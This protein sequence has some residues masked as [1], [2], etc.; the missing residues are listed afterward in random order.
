MEVT[1]MKRYVISAVLVF[2][3]LCSTHSAQAGTPGYGWH[4]DADGNGELVLDYPHARDLANSL[5]GSPYDPNVKRTMDSLVNWA[6]QF[7]GKIVPVANLIYNITNLVMSVDRFQMKEA[8]A[9]PNYEAYGFKMKRWVPYWCNKYSF[10]DG[11]LLR[12][13]GNAAVY[14]VV[15]DAKFWVPNGSFFNY[16]WNLIKVVPRGRLSNWYPWPKTGALLREQNN[17]AVNLIAYGTINPQYTWVSSTNQQGF[18]RRV[19]SYNAFVRLGLS[20]GN[21]R[22]VPDGAFNSPNPYLPRGIDLL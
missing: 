2:L 11:T 7:G 6:A 5:N 14:V 22:V 9:S 3:I 4:G 12:E 21:V 16:Q 17:P 10:N 13:D 8:T 19:L 15:A 20:W 18:V 1:G